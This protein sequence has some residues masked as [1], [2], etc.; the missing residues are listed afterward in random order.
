MTE[1]TQAQLDTISNDNK[2]R[3]ELVTLKEGEHDAKKVMKLTECKKEELSR[4]E[5]AGNTPRRV[6]VYLLKGDDWLDNGTGFCVGQIDKAKNAACFKVTNESNSDE[7][8]LQSYLEGSIQYQRQQD[9]LI[10]WTDQNGCDLALSFQESEG[11]ADLCDFIIKVQQNNLSPDISLYYVIPNVSEGEN[12]TELITGPVKYPPEIPTMEN[13]N[14]ILERINQGST[15]QFT[16]SNISE[17]LLD[18]DYFYKLKTIFDQSENEK[19]LTN[20]QLLSDII[21]SLFSY[22]ESPLLE[23]MLDSEE[24]ILVLASILEY[25]SEYPDYKADHREFLNNKPFKTVVPIDNVSIF[26]KDF[27]LTFMKDVVIARFADDSTYNFINSLIYSNQIEIFKYV[28]QSSILEK[29]FIMYDEENE[30]LSDVDLKR[31]GVRMLHQYVLIAKSSQKQDFFPLLVKAGVFKMI[32][33]ALQDELDSIRVLGTELIVIIIEQD[34]SLVNSIDHEE[35]TIDNLD[36]PSIEIPKNDEN[37]IDHDD[38]LTS[39]ESRLKL[40]DDMTLFTMLSKLLVEDSKNS[41]KIQAFEALK[42]LL[43]SNIANSSSAGTTEQDQLNSNNFNGE[44]FREINTNNYFKAFYSQV[45]PKIFEKIIN[46]RDSTIVSLSDNSLFQLSCE[47]ISFCTRE[48]EIHL[49]RPFFLNNN[50]LL[51]IS[52]LLINPDVKTILK[53]HV[54]RCLKNIILL[55][56]SSY[57]KYIISENLL[58]FFFKYFESIVDEN[59]L[60]NS[61]CLDLLEIITK[62]SDSK[63]NYKLLAKYIYE[64][65]SEFIKLKVGYVSLGKEFLLMVENNFYE[66]KSNGIALG[67]SNYDLVTTDDLSISDEELINNVSTPLN[68]DDH[69]EESAISKNDENKNEKEKEESNG[70]NKHKIEIKN[71]NNGNENGSKRPKNNSNNE[72]DEKCNNTK[73][74]SNKCFLVCNNTP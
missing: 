2:D 1:T 48:H 34:V 55:N 59:S 22:N 58:S 10:V 57:I 4:L 69:S 35:T 21:K 39:K 53:L 60:S 51:G 26:K 72:F 67:A 13:L 46:L 62:N 73:I 32:R 17:Y 61:T 19:N 42:T 30:Q 47:L 68:E 31:D 14:L 5:S 3:K 6:K 28:K 64:K 15:A 41:I 54:I 38:T 23:S 63:L 7:I 49:S 44:E 40:S 45:A 25:D 52:K 29:I 24:K 74:D 50:V 56:D 36:P 33:F 27:Y 37:E 43:D 20:L 70:K 8:L 9:T 66:S 18:I 12:I 65:W 71:E 11:C 16:R